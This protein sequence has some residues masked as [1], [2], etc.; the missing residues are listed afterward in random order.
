MSKGML[1]NTRSDTGRRMDVVEELLIN[2]GE[3]DDSDTS[4][5]KLE[6]SNDDLH[7]CSTDSAPTQTQ[8]K[9]HVVVGISN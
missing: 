1:P 6:P 3:D 7:Y 2:V 8:Q 4:E 5:D 9:N